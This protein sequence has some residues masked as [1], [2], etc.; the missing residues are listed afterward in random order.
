MSEAASQKAAMKCLKQICIAVAALLIFYGVL[1]LLNFLSDF[2]NV[3]VSYY[4][5]IFFQIVIAFLVIFIG[6]R[7]YSVARTIRQISL[8][9]LWLAARPHLLVLL[10]GCIT[11]LPIT[12]YPLS[13]SDLF[14]TQSFQPYSAHSPISFSYR[15]DYGWNFQGGG[16]IDM[17]T[18]QIYPTMPY[19][20]LV[21][22]IPTIQGWIVIPYKI[23]GS[24]AP[25][26]AL[27]PARAE[28]KLGVIVNGDYVFKVVMRDATDLF[29]IHKTDNMFWVEEVRVSLGSVVQKSGFEKR[30]DG[31]TIGYGWAESNEI[32]LYALDLIKGVGGEII[33][34]SIPEYPHPISIR[35]YFNDT[36]SKL[37]NIIL[38]LA[39]QYPNSSISIHANDKHYLSTYVYVGTIFVLPEYA[40]SMRSLIA[41]YS[42][43][44]YGEEIYKMYSTEQRKYIEFIE[45]HV[46]SAPI[47]KAFST[48]KYEIIERIQNE[49]GLKFGFNNHFL[50]SP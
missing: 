18:T 14:H 38:E 20:I 16:S 11:I 27:G 31:F 34:T 5:W 2:T 41:R 4:L 46:S 24:N 42:L 49:L 32:R 15:L 29:Q 22:V 6:L 10:L 8:G 39:K 35:F 40:D 47:E 9:Q 50:V 45:I 19:L 25:L 12:L 44:I 17:Y 33:D 28:I 43:V 1:H 37:S 3:A 21:D 13:A 7:V 26:Q 48:I 30:L 23:D 36:F